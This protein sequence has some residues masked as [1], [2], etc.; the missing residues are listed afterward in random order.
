MT[1]LA[2]N[3]DRL[4]T[5]TEREMVAQ[6]HPPVLDALTKEQILALGKRLREAR[7]RSRRIA[8]QQQREMRG[9][10]GPRG[11]AP[12]RDNTGSQGKTEVLVNALARLAAAMRQIKKTQA[13]QKLRKALDAKKAAVPHHPGSGRTASKGMKAKDST[14]RTVR[15]DPREVGRVSKSVKTAQ[16][17]RDR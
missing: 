1:A 13:A 9:K 7:D 2:Q 10:A 5:I 6:T 16:A 12:A 14:Q 8:S 3:E 4:L 17:K 15:V 11:A